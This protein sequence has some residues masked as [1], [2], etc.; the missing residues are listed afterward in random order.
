MTLS[1]R[2]RIFIAHLFVGAVMLALVT[3]LAAGEQRRW[4]VLRTEQALERAARHAAAGLPR[5][6][7]WDS[8]AD[9][10]GAGL[11]YRV[12]LMDRGGRVLGDSEVP[13][14]RLAQVENHATRPEMRAALDGSAGRALRHSR[15][16]QADLVYV[17]VPAPRGAA[18]ATLRLA[19]P[20]TVIAGMNAALLRLSLVAAL[21]ALLASA[22]LLAWVAGRLA[23][24][25]RALETVA[26][27]LGRGDATARARETPEDEL[28]RLGRA[29][30]R[31]AAEGRARL[32][33]LESERDERERILAHMRDGVALV[34]G[35]G[36]V[37]RMNRSFAELLG[38][39]LPAEPGTPFTEF[40]RGPEL[41]GMIRAA[42]DEARVVEGGVRLWAPVPRSLHA[43]A[44]PLGAAN[45]GAVLL[46][47][48]DLTESER[49]DRVRQ[50]FVANVSHELRTPLTSLRGYAETLLEGGLDD[51]ANREGFVRVIRD[52]AVRLE[53]L[54]ADLLSLAEL[55]RPGARPRGE[56]LDLRELAARQ[57]A[58]FLPRAAQAGLALAL[59][60]GEPVPVDADRGRLEQVLA[61]LLDNAVK[62]TERGGVSVS[63]GISA[64]RR[65]WCEVADTGS[66]IPPED[67]AR[68]FERFYRVDK[69][70]SR[71]QGGTGLGL[72]I[73]KHIVSLHG[74]E[75]SLMSRPGAG[76][77]FRF[78]IPAASAAPPGPAG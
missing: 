35:A 53:A 64:G 25:I 78:E 76:S 9:A 31:M 66:G 67:Q 6:A 37:V 14:D 21:L 45:P 68:V 15:T 61:N 48:H 16:V 58:A 5:A 24:R 3:V 73:V 36:R 13:R 7:D 50:D 43:V 77:T 69:A 34:D 2:S 30:N 39:M 28:G 72:S 20:L 70:R 33:A 11:G 41:D 40:V 4:V 38:A 10:L 75:V 27:R 63:L 44:T 57:V 46:V 65:A 62:Y 74:G 22:P 23:T 71:A 12:T 17:A 26:E 59:A 29:M 42:H 18:P 8:L 55:E 51:A 32:E 49:L 54:A 52:Q 1:L 60:P 47:L 19:E 56:R